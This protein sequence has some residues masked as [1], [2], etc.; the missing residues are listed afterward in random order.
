M[1]LTEEDLQTLLEDGID[2]I[3]PG[4]YAELL[5]D[6][7]GNILRGHGRDYA[8]HLFL[9][10]KPNQVQPLKEWIRN[11]S[12]NI[13]SAQKQ[14]QEAVRFRTT[15]IIGSTFFNFFLSRKGYESLEFPP[16]KIP[17]DQPFRFGM[18]NDAIRNLLGDPVIEEW[19]PGLQQEI[20]ALLLIADDNLDNIQ[21]AVDQITQQLEPIAQVIH[22]EN[23]FILRNDKGD[24][25]EHFGFIDGISQPLFLKRD[26]EKA[27]ESSD[28]SKWDPRAPLSL[29]LAK[30]PN[31]KLEDSYGSYLVYRK[32]EQDVNAFL[33]AEEFLT[34]ELNIDKE[35]AGALITGRFRDGTALT[36]SNV[37]D[38]EATKNNFDYSDDAQAFKC[39]FHSHVR[40]SNPRGDTGRVNSSGETYEQALEKE[41]GHRI[42]RRGISFGA[43]DQTKAISNRAGLL[44]LCFQADIANQFNFIQSAWSNPNNFVEVNV[45]TDPIIGQAAPDARNQK[46]PITW[47]EPA[48]KPGFNFQLWVHLK[49]GEY[50]FAP[51]ISSLK[52][53]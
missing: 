5:S 52:N 11:F 2:A 28:F 21:Q 9:Q 12:Q 23:G 43:S 15:K 53:I 27:R 40:K 1:A 33:Q 36:L 32:L 41:R 20:H 37:P 14:T 24:I 8:V 6:L 13:T 3:N 17:G 4:E 29:V 49:G 39:P 35:L 45:G 7:Q 22:R 16:F 25:I 42:A 10:F 30:D 34:G 44:F 31:G 48:T 47:G 50:F 19:E 26:I 38:T 46:W 18:K 51:S